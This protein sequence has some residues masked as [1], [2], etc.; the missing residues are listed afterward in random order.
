MI[1]NRSPNIPCDISGGGGDEVD[2]VS[3][4][5]GRHGHSGVSY[6]VFTIKCMVTGKRLLLY[7][8]Y[9]YN[10]RKFL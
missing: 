3:F 10:T 1:C 2:P 8:V 9:K 5:V 4:V 6:I 7:I